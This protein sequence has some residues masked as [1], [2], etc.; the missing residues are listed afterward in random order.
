MME[1]TATP[2]AS[3]NVPPDIQVRLTDWRKLWTQSARIHYLFGGFS[4][5]FSAIA[6]ATGGVL[7]QYLSAVAA[8]LT[9]LIGFVHPERRY[10]KFV[11][12]W[13]VLDVAALRYKFGIIE[14]KEL[15]DAV[16]RGETLISEFEEKTE[17]NDGPEE[18]AK[19]AAE[20]TDSKA[21]TE[22]PEKETTE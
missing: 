22:S 15:C 7:A 1:P 12:A 9:A 20:P 21:T 17:S 4:V 11:R 6:A 10:L 18:A 14:V 13:R 8:V 19:K 2:V 3:R 16:E 5:A